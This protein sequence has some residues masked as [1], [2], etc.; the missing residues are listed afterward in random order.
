MYMCKIK[1]MKKILLL[2]LVVLVS[3]SCAEQNPKQLIGCERANALSYKIDSIN[4]WYLQECYNSTISPSVYSSSEEQE[5]DDTEELK[6]KDDTSVFLADAVGFA[7][8][9]FLGAE[10]GAILG[11]VVCP[12]MG[13]LAGGVGD[14]IATGVTVAMVCSILAADRNNKDSTKNSEIYWEYEDW[15]YQNDAVVFDES[16]IASNVGWLHNAIITSLGINREEIDIEILLDYSSNYLESN[17]ICEFYD[18]V[19]F[20][21]NIRDQW[22]CL[23]E[24]LYNSDFFANYYPIFED[25]VMVFEQIEE[26]YRFSYTESIMI[27]ISESGLLEEDMYRLNGMISTFYY[28]SLLWNMDAVNN[29]RP[30]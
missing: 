2:L 13:T 16:I 8:G 23:N 14:A 15:I 21:A 30:E 27:E 20:C 9:S 19:Q 4:T 10:T 28:S 6:K 26:D 11:T 1:H 25:Y 18:R 5:K 7:S 22:S 12:G 3:F 17:S 29:I 24:N